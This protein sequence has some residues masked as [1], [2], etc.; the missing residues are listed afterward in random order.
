MRIKAAAVTEIIPA[1]PIGHD[2]PAW[3]ITEI[4]VTLPQ[5]GETAEFNVTLL[6]IG[7]GI[8]H[9][10]LHIAFFAAVWMDCYTAD[11]RTCERSSGATK[12]YWK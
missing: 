9:Q 7:D 10:L 3:L 11:C 2:A 8:L 12:S 1:E 5:T 6:H 4:A